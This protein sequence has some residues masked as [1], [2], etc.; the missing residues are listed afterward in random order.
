MH[1]F[2]PF[3]FLE[4]VIFF[5]VLR[6]EGLGRGREERERERERRHKLPFCFFYQPCI[7]W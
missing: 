1:A 7:F 5:L 2:H 4:E 3:V 6:G